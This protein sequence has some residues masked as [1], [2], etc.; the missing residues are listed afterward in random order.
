MSDNGIS[1]DGITLVN[2]RPR[3]DSVIVDEVDAKYAAQNV[4]VNVSN[5]FNKKW[6]ILFVV[7]VLAIITFITVILLTH[8]KS[9][10]S[11]GEVPKNNGNTKK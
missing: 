6:I 1:A 8:S 11:R 3:G 2:M 7:F 5:R 10:K 9:A 4:V